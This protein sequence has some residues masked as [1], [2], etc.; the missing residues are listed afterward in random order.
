MLTC[1]GKQHSIILSFQIRP[2]AT[3]YTYAI[4]KDI[5]SGMRGYQSRATL[6]KPMVNC[7]SF[8]ESCQTNVI[9]VLV[10]A[11]IDFIG[12][13][14]ILIW[15]IEVGS[16]FNGEWHVVLE[17]QVEFSRSSFGLI[18]MHVRSYTYG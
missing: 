2:E 10:A 13:S 9:M 11:S 3:N 17:F 16:I 12:S 8:T 4:T 6:N 14:V 7:V 1:A 18:M 15:S 5:F